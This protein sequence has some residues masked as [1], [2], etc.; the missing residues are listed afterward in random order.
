M[1]LFNMLAAIS[2]AFISASAVA[3]M[4]VSE[5]NQAGDGNTAELV[6]T[7]TSHQAQQTQLG[8]NSY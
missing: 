4:H 6:Q 5:I 2:M 7:G 1:R 3:Q 8:N